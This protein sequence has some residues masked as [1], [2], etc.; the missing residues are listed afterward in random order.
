[1]NVPRKKPE[2]LVAWPESA[3]EMLRALQSYAR[4]RSAYPHTKFELVLFCHTVP[5]GEVE[6]VLSSEQSGAAAGDLLARYLDAF[7]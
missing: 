1:M 3:D 2:V 4:L 7:D 6:A 5:Q